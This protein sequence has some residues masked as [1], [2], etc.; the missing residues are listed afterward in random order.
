MLNPLKPKRNYRSKFHVCKYANIC[1]TISRNS[2]TDI[3]I[4]RLR[5]KVKCPRC[6]QIIPSREEL[7]YH[8]E[9]KHSATK[10]AG[11][12]YRC[13]VNHC[14]NRY[15]CLKYLLIHHETNHSDGDPTKVCE[16]QC[17]ICFKYFSNKKN[18]RDH[19]RSIHSSRSLACDICGK[20]FKTRY[21]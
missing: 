7:K 8:N 20:K 21:N 13:V 15:N 19:M 3:I 11:R 2:F 18:L 10:K 12:P 14:K 4:F 9:E 17:K 16:Y 6:K 5:K 1:F